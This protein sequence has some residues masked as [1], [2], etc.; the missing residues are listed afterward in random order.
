MWKKISGFQADAPAESLRSVVY[1]VGGFSPGAGELAAMVRKAF[2]AEQVTFAPDP[3][4]QAI[5]D[6][7]PEDVDDACARR[8]RGFQPSYDLH[9]TFEEYLVPNVRRRYAGG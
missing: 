5:A 8:D 2:P 4:R 9:R 3:R 6:S 7:W 1:N